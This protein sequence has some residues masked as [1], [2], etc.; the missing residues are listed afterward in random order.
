MIFAKTYDNSNDA[1]VDIVVMILTV[2]WCAMTVV[3]F[4]NRNEE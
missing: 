3:H 2:K 4:N 1:S